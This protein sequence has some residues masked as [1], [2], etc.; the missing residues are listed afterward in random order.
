MRQTTLTGEVA[1]HGLAEGESPRVAA[2]LWITP[3]KSPWHNALHHLG[4]LLIFRLKSPLPPSPPPPTHTHTPETKGNRKTGFNVRPSKGS[5]DFDF[6][7]C[8]KKKLCTQELLGNSRPLKKKMENHKPFRIRKE[9]SGRRNN[10][11]SQNN[12]VNWSKYPREGTLDQARRS[13]KLHSICSRA[14]RSAECIVFFQLIFFL[15]KFAL[16]RRSGFASFCEVLQR[17]LIE[18]LSLG[19]GQRGTDIITSNS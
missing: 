7:E 10:M 12:G 17:P 2:I 9:E 15:L 8:G 3:I 16:R 5:A 1:P 4:C 6:P 19:G 13:I 11:Q 14:W 18:R